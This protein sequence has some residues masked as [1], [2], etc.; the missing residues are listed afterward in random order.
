MRWNGMKFCLDQK[1]EFKRS[2]RLYHH[3]FARV[4]MKV[5]VNLIHFACHGQKW[6]KCGEYLMK[7]SSQFKQ[8]YQKSFGLL[9]YS[10][11]MDGITTNLKK[12]N[13][14]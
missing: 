5:A 3:I 8:I 1:V 11:K 6:V 2:F 12:V 7:F 14:I 9:Q 10:T 13:K 4:I